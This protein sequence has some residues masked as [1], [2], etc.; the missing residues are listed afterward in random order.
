MTN[1]GY[2][3]LLI[4]SR[5]QC[6]SIIK[7]IRLKR[8]VTQKLL[9]VVSLLEQKQKRNVFNK[10]AAESHF[11][12]LSHLFNTRLASIFDKFYSNWLLIPQRPVD[13]DIPPVSIPEGNY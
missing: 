5:L 3:V 13:P 11:F 12:F 2:F 8:N 10:L 4:L 6:K 9:I 1:H 7:N